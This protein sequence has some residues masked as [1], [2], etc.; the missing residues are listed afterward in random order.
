[1]AAR[2]FKSKEIKRVTRT[3][4]IVVTLMMQ[5]LI[6]KTIALLNL[7]VL[8][9]EDHTSSINFVVLTY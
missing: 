1:M 8:S 4:H 2:Q 6:V 3:T 7:N 5:I 9:L